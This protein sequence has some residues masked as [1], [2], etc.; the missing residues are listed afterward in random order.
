MI[1]E[2]AAHVGV[3]TDHVIEFVPGSGTATK[4]EM[5]STRHSMCNSS[6]SP[7]ALLRLVQLITHRSNC[8]LSGYACGEVMRRPLNEGTMTMG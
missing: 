3:A 2:G 4:P 8:Q 7:C 1:A 6:Q 5:A